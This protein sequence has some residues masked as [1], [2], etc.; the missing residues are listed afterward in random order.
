MKIGGDNGQYK[1]F[2]PYLLL[3]SVIY[4]YLPLS[5]SFIFFYLPLFNLFIRCDSLFVLDDADALRDDDADAVVGNLLFED[6]HEL[7]VVLG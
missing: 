5:S 3:S 2:V 4:L 7:V 1:A 6:L